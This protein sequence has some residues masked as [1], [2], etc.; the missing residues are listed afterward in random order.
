LVGARH[1]ILRVRHAWHASGLWT[2]LGG[3]F[4]RRLRLAEPLATGVDGP[5]DGEADGSGCGRNG[6]LSNSSVLNLVSGGAETEVG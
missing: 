3:I 6:W 1:A 2:C 4:E 5:G